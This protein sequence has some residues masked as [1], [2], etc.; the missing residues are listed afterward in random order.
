MSGR[1]RLTF[2]AIAAV[3]AVVAVVVLASG[4]GGE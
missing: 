4:D 1:Q 3:I 2:L